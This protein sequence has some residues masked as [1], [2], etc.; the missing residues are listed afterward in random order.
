MN[1]IAIHKS[2]DK[3]GLDGT[4]KATLWTH[5]GTEA[6]RLQ[7]TKIDKF[8]A[9]LKPDQVIRT[10]QVNATDATLMELADRGVKIRYAHWHS[11][12]FDKSMEPATIAEHYQMAPDSTF[13]DFIPRHDINDLRKTL[14]LRNA[15]LQCYGD[16]VRRFK[17]VGRSL[18]LTTDAELKSDPLIS[19]ALE[20]LS[21]IQ[22]SVLGESGGSLDKEVVKLAKTIPECVLFNQV[23]GIQSSWILAAAV[24]STSG[25]FDRFDDVASL[26]H[27]YGLHVVDGKAPKR[28]KGTPMDWSP[29]GRMTAYQLGDVIIKGTDWGGKREANPWRAKYDEYR[30][31][32]R[33]NHED[34]CK[35][36]TPDGHSTARARRKVVKAI[37]KRFFLAVKGES[38]VEG[39]NPLED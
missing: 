28:A 13:R 30:E 32:E 5:D 35:C 1:P 6:Q 16:T 23:A 24:V 17:Q 33:L 36:T 2:F 10:T 34:K 26:W 29:F 31:I 9:S 27:Y 38:F 4:R 21:S 15:L 19:Q 39:H 12:G 7:G 22:K 25:G 3:S 18:N 8:I 20:G 11:L 37:F 14:S